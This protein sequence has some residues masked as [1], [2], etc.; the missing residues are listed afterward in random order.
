MKTDVQAPTLQP[1]SLRRLAITTSAAMA[2]AAVILITSV[3]PAEYGI[4]PLGTGNALGL[5]PLAGVVNPIVAEDETPADAKLVP[6]QQGPVGHYKAPYKTDKTTFVLGPYEYIEYKYRLEKDA[7]MLYSWTADGGLLHD[8]H[9]DRDGAPANASESFDKEARR[10]A[11]GALTAPFSG[12]HGWFWENPG[13]ETIT[14]S[15]A[16]AGFYASAV[17]IRRDKSR[18]PRELAPVELP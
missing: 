8:L 10:Q 11:S 2:V 7:T 16:S 18:H 9:G 1:P 13:G 4:D 6:T 14:V 12:I 3:L 15:L 5:M 17:E